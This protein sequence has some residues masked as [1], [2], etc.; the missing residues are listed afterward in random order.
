MG[1]II[2]TCDPP[3]NVMAAFASDAMGEAIFA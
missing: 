1:T 3:A 2:I